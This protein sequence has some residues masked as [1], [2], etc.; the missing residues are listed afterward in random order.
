MCNVIK[1]EL[2]LLHINVKQ[3]KK[4]FSNIK[5]KV[6]FCTT[7]RKK[8]SDI[9]FFP[10]LSIIRRLHKQN[11]FC[12]FHPI[13]KLHLFSAASSGFIKMSD[14]CTEERPFSHVQP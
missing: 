7:T 3:K 1:R 10:F 6:T 2:Q 5:V 8:L 4:N 11:A 13:F 9:F 14:L 12:H